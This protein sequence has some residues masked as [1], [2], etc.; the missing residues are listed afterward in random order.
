MQR[1]RQKQKQPKHQKKWQQQIYIIVQILWINNAFYWSHSL[2][3]MIRW[4]EK[5]FFLCLS[6][7]FFFAHTFKIW[8]CQRWFS[9]VEIWLKSFI[10][11][12][13]L[14]NNGIVYDEFDE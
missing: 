1:K 6:D 3:S 13:K 7:A 14:F 9:T 5:T 8:Q 4:E 10:I 12:I 2:N 11:H